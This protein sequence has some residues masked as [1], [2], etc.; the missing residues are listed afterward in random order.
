M[1]DNRFD[2]IRPYYDS[3]LPEA[4]ERIAQWELFPQVARFIYPDLS[5]DE[6]RKRL[7][8]TKTIHGFQS[9]FM[10]DAIIHL[11]DSCNRRYFSVTTCS[12]CQ[13]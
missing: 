7:C 9:S 10:N 6:A 8:E 12:H 5:A 11:P 1:D 13:S 4:L 3:E 2:D